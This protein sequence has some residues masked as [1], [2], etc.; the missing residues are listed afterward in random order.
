MSQACVLKRDS[1][2]GYINICGD[3][4]FTTVSGL[5][6]SARDMF[7]SLVKL[8]I[9]LAKVSSSDS[10]GLALL[11]DWMRLAKQNNKKIIF[12]NI[13]EQMLAMARASGLDELLPLQ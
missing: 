13:P 5:L 4:T 6:S 10:A 12:H 8:D 3:L 1:E 11:I 2:T 9:D 7:A